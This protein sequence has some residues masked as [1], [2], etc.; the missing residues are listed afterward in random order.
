MR[1]CVSI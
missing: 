1:N